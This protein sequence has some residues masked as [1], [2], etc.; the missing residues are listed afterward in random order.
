MENILYKLGENFVLWVLDIPEKATEE[1]INIIAE[2]DC[3]NCIIART[4]L[5]WKLTEEVREKIWRILAQYE[6]SGCST[7]GT[8]SEIM[9]E[10]N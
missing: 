3:N 1:I 6:T 9:E 7:M 2:N 4:L 8:L 5:N 10:L